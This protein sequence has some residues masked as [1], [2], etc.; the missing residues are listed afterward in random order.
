MVKIGEGG[1]QV[2][3]WE[4]LFCLGGK[5][6]SLTKGLGGKGS[7]GRLAQPASAL[8]VGKKGRTKIKSSLVIT[9]VCLI[10]NTEEMTGFCKQEK[11]KCMPCCKAKK[12]Y[13]TNHLYLSQ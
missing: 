7:S 6:F 3:R 4:L 11:K 10:S 13:S 8:G 9:Q 5:G 1:L 2:S 12:I